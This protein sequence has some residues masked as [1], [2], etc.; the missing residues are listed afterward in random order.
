MTIRGIRLGRQHD[1]L[2]QATQEL[3]RLRTACRIVQHR[4][5]ICDFR[6]V[7]TPAEAEE[8]FYAK[9]NVIDMIA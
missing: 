4:R 3:H 1:L 6:R 5:Q 7:N 8:A 2:D 9:L